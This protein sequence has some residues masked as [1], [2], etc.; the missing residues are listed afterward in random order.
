MQLVEPVRDGVK[1]RQSILHHIGI[2]MDEVE[3]EQLKQL[4]EYIKA[5]MLDECQPSLFA[6]EELADH[7]FRAGHQCDDKREL[8]VDLKQLAEEQRVVK[9]IHEVY[10][11]TFRQRGLDRLL[12]RSRYRASHD[13]LF[14]TVMAR[15]ANPDSK[16]GSVRRLE[17]DLGVSLSLEKVYR[18]MDRL[19]ANVIGRLQTRV[20]EASRS[21]LPEPSAVLFFDC[22]MLVFETSVENELRQRDS[23]GTGNRSLPRC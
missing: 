16:R 8:R 21:M 6:P 11:D 10:G 19:D 22:A 3:L 7:V 20:G 17:K 15:I 14:H 1:V 2:A 18:M 23:V 13:V 4:G 12:R 9:G 5:K